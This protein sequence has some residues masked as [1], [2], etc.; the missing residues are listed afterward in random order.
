MNQKPSSDEAYRSDL[1]AAQ[2]EL[3]KLQRHF[4]KHGRKLLIIFEGRDG[5]GKDGMIKTVSEHM[6]PRETRIIA[7]PKPSDRELHLWYFQRYTAHLP[8][9]GEIVLFN[10]S[11]YN[12]AGVERVMG[13]CNGAE[14]EAFFNSVVPFEALLVDSGIHILKYYLDIALDEQQ[15]RLKKR[16]EDP[17]KQWKLSPIDDQAVA[18]WNEYS[19]AR[20]DMLGR[21]NTALAPWYVVDANDKH[22]ARLNVIRHVLASCD[23][24]DKDRALGGPDP[25]IVATPT[26]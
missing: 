17:L 9:A 22:S 19:Q 3:V 23:Y 15:R 7:L 24:R 14:V 11:W 26:Q 21:T 25:S 18:L 13:F 10:R 5:S 1:R 16:R 8:A 20:D 12:R 4:I 2:I 6:S